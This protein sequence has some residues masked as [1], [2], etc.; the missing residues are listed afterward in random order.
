MDTLPD[1]RSALEWLAV[2]CMAATLACGATTGPPEIVVDRTACAHCSMLVSETRF[3]A[4][5]RLPDGT[6]LTF[7]DVGC[8]LADLAGRGVEPEAVWVRDYSGDEWIR[9]D[10]ATFVRGAAPSTPMAGGL[11]SFASVIAAREFADEHGGDVL[12]DLPPPLVR[13][14]A[15]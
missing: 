5:Y 14:A 9:A 6:A 15:R 7:D 11:V 10:D 4:A 12:D 8:L 3:A 13:S 2:A 1:A